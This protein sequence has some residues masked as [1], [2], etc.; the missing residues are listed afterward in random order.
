MSLSA[1]FS[2]KSIAVLGASS[3]PG[4]V[5]NDIV[6]NLVASFSGKIFPINPK[7]GELYGLPVCASIADVPQAVDLAVIC[8]PAAIVETV[9]VEAGKK[10][11]KAAVVI[12]A[13]FKEVGNGEL[14]QKIVALARKYGFTLVGP[15]CLG[16]INAHLQMNASFAPTMPKVGSIAFLSQSGAL[17]VAVLDY[18]KSSN[19]GISK[20]LSV[21]NKA[22]LG[23]VKLLEYLAN[24]P[25]TKVILLYVEELSDFAGILK[26]AHK[27]RQQRHPKPIIVLKSG[28]T[29]RGAQ[30]AQS[31]TGALMGSTALYDALF[32]QA[33]MI[34]AETIEELFLYAECFTYNPL[35]KKDR[36]AVVTN[37]GGLGVL[38]TDALVRSH[39]QLASLSAET[40]KQLSSFLPAAA[41]IHNPIDILG[42]ADAVR[43]TKTLQI[44]AQ[45]KGVD[46]L[47]ILLTPQSMTEVEKT[48]R[49]IAELKRATAKPII[50][51]FL[52]G[53]R[54]TKGIAILQ[55]SEVTGI[56]FPE[57]TAL[58]LDILHRFSTWK[59]AIAPSYFRNIDHRKV[60]TILDRHTA[61][62]SWLSE[63]SVLEILEAY[64][65]PVVPWAFVT[66]EKELE[67]ALSVCGERVVL[68]IISE[69]IIHKSE[70]GGV[71][72]NVRKETIV[73]EFNKL[74]TKIKNNF[75]DAKIEGILVMQQLEKKG[76]ELIIGG[77]RDRH[78]GALI[79][80]GMGGIFTE[81]FNDAA[82]GLAPL[83]K[84][85][86]TD[87]IERLKIA[88]ILKGSRGQDA[89]DIQAITTILAKVS[90]LFEQ[91]P[92]IAELD[93]NPVVVFEKSQG[94]AI[95][96]ARIRT[97]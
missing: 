67:H 70:A 8:V 17:G 35:L 7:K 42:D 46:A 57:L 37:A 16:V 77:V 95:L 19:I 82:F 6:K 5:G 45:D 87:M 26:T 1:V 61:K 53:E 71:V 72:L 73:T 65:L 34:Q 74:L 29:S 60:H 10:K 48:A 66:K 81:T 56:R 24:D 89:S 43:Y 50:V 31:H 54:V 49:S 79:G 51:S 58:G 55:Q 25:E 52:G 59:Q 23:E 90:Q 11:I 63:V 96:D 44:V 36:V 18:A 38:T 39:L 92:M 62:H 30:A 83:S 47:V 4:S 94:A 20:F 15:N 69:D 41:S 33:G 97:F 14:E 93:I 85:E 68:K 76:I 28:K 32:R 84:S 88:P 78:L 91:Y 12:S 80:C 22:A 40:K 64:D 86:V 3:Q 27:L 2:P 75:P 21:G 9:L 13:G